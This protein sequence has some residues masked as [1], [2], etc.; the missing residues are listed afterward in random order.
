[1]NSA[2]TF[3]VSPAIEQF[4]NAGGNQ[5]R[6]RRLLRLPLAS[7]AAALVSLSIAKDVRA[8]G[9]SSA[10]TAKFAEY[11]KDDRNKWTR[12]VKAANIQAE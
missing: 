12:V 3:S 11:F 7:I 6:R 5:N 2:A 1:M 8:Q 9:S 4:A 10:T